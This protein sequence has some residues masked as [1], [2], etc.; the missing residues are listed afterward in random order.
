MALKM[1]N[2]VPTGT[3]PNPFDVH[4]NPAQGQV[5]V[6]KVTTQKDGSKDEKVLLQENPTVHSGIQT[7]GE[8]CKVRV[9]GGTTIQT[10]P[11]ENVRIDVH[12]EVPC[13]KSDID[14][15]YEF[16][17]DWVSEKIAAAIKQVKG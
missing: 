8:P 10:V 6:T 17:S 15:T 5:A 2:N 7:K 1:N 12:L 16:A 3:K 9:G 13:E 14:S 11:Y 4:L